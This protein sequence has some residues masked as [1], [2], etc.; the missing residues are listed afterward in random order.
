MISI[1]LGEAAQ[2]QPLG[3]AACEL[4]NV[5]SNVIIDQQDIGLLG[6]PSN[7]L[8]CLIFAIALPNLCNKD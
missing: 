5:R 1:E 6:L 7:W 8:L 2:R 4:E 3:L